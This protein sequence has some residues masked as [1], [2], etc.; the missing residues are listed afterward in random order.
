MV[1]DS[2]AGVLPNV[3]LEGKPAVSLELV[4]VDHEW[5]GEEDARVVVMLI[6]G[7]HLDRVLFW[8]KIVGKLVE[9]GPR[10]L[11]VG[12]ALEIFDRSFINLLLFTTRPSN[13]LLR[14]HPES[15]LVS[16]TILLL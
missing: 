10:F 11:V 13:G 3:F 1:I 6:Q 14:I 8:R 16:V 15:H 2:D 12:V 5:V 7:C 4:R 9:N